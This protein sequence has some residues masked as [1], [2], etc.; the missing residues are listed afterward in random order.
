MNTHRINATGLSVAALL[1]AGLLSVSAG[2]SATVIEE[3]TVTHRAVA[4]TDEANVMPW[5][6][7]D[8]QRVAAH[9][10]LN[11]EQRETIKAIFAD[12][13]PELDALRKKRHSNQKAL[14]TLDASSADYAA[15]LERLTHERAALFA[16]TDD[17]REYVR[18]EVESVLSESQQSRLASLVDG[19]PAM[20]P[21]TDSD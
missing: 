17:M 16:D 2:A 12:V 13:R 9:L 7:D 5:T 10:A 20:R 21:E 8:R 4:T 3:I 1:A 14:E 15:A 11:A 19:T 18:A 6:S